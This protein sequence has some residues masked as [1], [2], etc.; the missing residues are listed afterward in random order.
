MSE[1]LASGLQK[2]EIEDVEE[3]TESD[4]KIVITEI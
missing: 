4:H 1:G 3:I 2:A